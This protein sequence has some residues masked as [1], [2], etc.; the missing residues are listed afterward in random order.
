MQT[1]ALA[2]LVGGPAEQLLNESGWQVQSLA[3]GSYL[4]SGPIF[5]QSG[6]GSLSYGI[7]TAYSWA[8]STSIKWRYFPLI[9]GSTMSLV[10]SGRAYIATTLPV[11][12]VINTTTT[13][14][15]NPGSLPLW[16]KGMQYA[17]VSADGV[18]VDPADGIVLPSLNR[19]TLVP[20]TMWWDSSNK[21]FPVFSDTAGAWSAF[22]S[23]IV[24]DIAAALDTGTIN[25]WIPVQ[26][27]V[28]GTTNEYW[29]FVMFNA[30]NQASFTGPL[31]FTFNPFPLPITG[32]GLGTYNATWLIVLLT[33]TIGTTIGVDGVQI[34]SVIRAAIACGPF[35]AISTSQPWNNTLITHYM[36]I[37]GWAWNPG[38]QTFGG[39]SN[40]NN[41]V[42]GLCQMVTINSTGALGTVF[43]NIQSIGGVQFNRQS[44]LLTGS[45]QRTS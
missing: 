30:S 34:P 45:A 16:T 42:I 38:T 3:A 1:Q 32:G 24:Y 5:V 8:D 43:L 35:P 41:I 39:I 14:S 25:N 22:Q 40:A 9:G 19:R 10:I 12:P 36:N 29:G 18:Q 44:Q 17:A 7:D 21:L 28:G 37:P 11:T 26:S 33:S 4:I 23:D 6:A 27:T 2:P 20:N 15:H 31:A 13:A